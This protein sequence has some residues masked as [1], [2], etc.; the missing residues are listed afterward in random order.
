MH[1][2]VQCVNSQSKRA[3]ALHFAMGKC[4]KVETT[5]MIRSLATALSWRLFFVLVSF[6]KE[7][8]V[9]SSSSVPF[10]KLLKL[11]STLYLVS[12]SGTGTLPGLTTSLVEIPA[13]VA[14]SISKGLSL[15]KSTLCLS[16]SMLI[17]L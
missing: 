3:A 1:A 13:S 2:E 16:V 11:Y 14:A 4:S 7:H 9:P 8:C 6:A 15:R 5:N 12:A 17:A 10:Y